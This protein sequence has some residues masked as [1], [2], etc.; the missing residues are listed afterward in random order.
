MVLQ[1]LKE[2]RQKCHALNST[3]ENHVP[4]STHV[5]DFLKSLRLA[6][7]WMGKLAGI[8]GKENP[9][10][11][12]GNRHSKED[13]EPIVDVSATYLN[14]T[15][16]NQVERIDW[17]RQELNS[18]LST[19]NTLSEGESTS[20][21]DAITCLISIYQHLGEARFHLGFELGRIR[22]EK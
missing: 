4:S 5:A 15:N 20:A 1:V 10:K 6:R 7:A 12:D 8:V 14:I 16:L 9:Y 19:F 21:I 18:L 17:L 22:D 2:M 13:I 3:T 11:K